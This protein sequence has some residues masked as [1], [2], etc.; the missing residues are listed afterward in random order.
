MTEA[1]AWNSVPGG[2]ERQGKLS[3][4]NLYEMMQQ[5]K[6]F[7]ERCG[8]CVE[9]MND[10]GLRVDIDE[11]VP[12]IPVLP[13]LSQKKPSFRGEYGYQSQGLKE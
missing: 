7:A 2:E 13:F 3:R 10:G 5:G 4:G 11:H 8:G 9:K 6:E 12:V 1:W